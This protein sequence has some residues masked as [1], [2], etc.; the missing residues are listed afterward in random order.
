MPGG[1]KTLH[2]L[3]LYLSYILSI[4]RRKMMMEGGGNKSEE[5]GHITKY[6]IT[7]PN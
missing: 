6:K 7:K 5:R 1:S 4:L 2:I 3:L